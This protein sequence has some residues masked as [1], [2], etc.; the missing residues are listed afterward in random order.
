MNKLIF[1]FIVALNPIFAKALEVGEIKEK[2]FVLNFINTIKTK[3]KS[4]ISNLISYPLRFDVPVPPIE[5]NKEF[6]ERFDEV[7]D[8]KTLEL[9]ASSDIEKDWSRVG[10]RGVM[11]DN[12]TIWL[13]DNGKLTAITYRTKAQTIARQK[14]ISKQKNSLHE[15][16]REFR[17]PVGDWQTNKFHIR[18]DQLE[19]GKY[20][21][22]A[23]KINLPTS[24]VP[25]LVISDGRYVELESG[26]AGVT[27]S[28]YSFK[29]GPYEYR[30][31][32]DEDLYLE[33]LKNNKKILTEAVV[34]SF[35]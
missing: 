3:N 1:C 25:S 34:D 24:E 33:V 35:Y 16:V 5:N 22:V 12:G 18:I 17:E 21:Y 11:L 9:I 26:S 13:D 7:F 15:S 29:N 23:W 6:V 27:S 19:N 32:S 8:S 10:W 20:R 31:V 4:N 28:Y 30:V 14:I 2:K